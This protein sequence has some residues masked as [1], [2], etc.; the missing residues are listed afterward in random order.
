MSIARWEFQEGN[1]PSFQLVGH[2]SGTIQTYMFF[3]I[4][5]DKDYLVVVRLQNYTYI[6]PTIVDVVN[7]WIQWKNTQALGC[8]KSHGDF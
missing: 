7:A 8:L 1:S 4:I 3:A 2:E 6:D 5:C